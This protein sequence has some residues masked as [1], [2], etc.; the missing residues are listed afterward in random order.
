MRTWRNT[1]PGQDSTAPRCS[2]KPPTRAPDPQ[3]THSTRRRAHP[4][5]ITL[6]SPLHEPFL[7]RIDARSIRPGRAVWGNVNRRVRNPQACCTAR[8]RHV[9]APW[10]SAC[11]H[12]AGFARRLVSTLGLAPFARRQRFALLGLAFRLWFVGLFLR[13]RLLAWFAG[14]G[15]P[16]FCRGTSSGPGAAALPVWGVL[17]GCRPGLLLW[18]AVALWW[19]GGRVSQPA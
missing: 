4:P 13:F 18:P 19:G 5:S 15:I 14:A 2:R 8:L 16:R 1:R 17:S 12:A 7:L 10:A 3:A 6:R 9:S 11:Q